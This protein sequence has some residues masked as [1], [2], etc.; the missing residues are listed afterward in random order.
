MLLFTRNI[1]I[2]FFA[3][4]F[5]ETFIFFQRGAKIWTQNNC[6]NFHLKRTYHF[7]IKTAFYLWWQLLLLLMQSKSRLKLSKN[8][9]ES[10][11]ERVKNVK[12]INEMYKNIKSCW[13][14]SLSSTSWAEEQERVYVLSDLLNATFYGLSIIFAFESS[15]K[16]SK[17]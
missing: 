13:S 16:A 2:Y 10:E 6:K 14:S 3:S 17:I 8:R 7:R 12:L 9:A 5:I 1:S 11:R 4:L 15:A